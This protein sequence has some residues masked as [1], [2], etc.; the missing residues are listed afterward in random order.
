MSA[1][2]E[3]IIIIGLVLSAIICAWAVLTPNHLFVG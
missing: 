3:K 1:I 2:L